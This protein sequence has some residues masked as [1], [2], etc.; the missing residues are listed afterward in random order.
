MWADLGAAVALVLVIEGLLPAV[1]PR[2]YRKAVFA[3]AQ[4]HSSALRRAGLASMVIG[5]ALLYL[6][7]H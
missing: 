6:V 5:A 3:M 4:L 1:S 2:L 7:K